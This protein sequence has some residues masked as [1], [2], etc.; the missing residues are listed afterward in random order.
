MK[1]VL[2]VELKEAL[3][4][5]LKAALLFWK[6]LSMVLTKWGFVVNPHDTCVMNKIMKGKQCTI[7]WHVND[8]KISHEDQAIVTEVIEHLEKEFGEE[9]PPYKETRKGS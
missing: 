6:K 3:Y 8:L 4:G 1:M 7:L 2:Y 9:A 5:T